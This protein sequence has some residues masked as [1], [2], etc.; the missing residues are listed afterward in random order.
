MAE[1]KRKWQHQEAIVQYFEKEWE[2]N[3]GAIL[4]CW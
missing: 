3:I 2:G 1:F 4:P